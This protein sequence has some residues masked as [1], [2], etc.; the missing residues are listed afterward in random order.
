[1]FAADVAAVVISNRRTKFPYNGLTPDWYKRAAAP[2]DC[3][4]YDQPVVF[5]SP[6]GFVARLVRVCDRSAV[7][8]TVVVV[9]VNG[10][11]KTGRFLNSGE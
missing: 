11:E 6:D 8:E 3:V 10:G 7:P 5:V 2:D 4:W 9:A 1:M